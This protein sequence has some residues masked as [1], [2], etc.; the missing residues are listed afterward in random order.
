M[1]SCAQPSAIGTPMPDA[2]SRPELLPPSF[3][4]SSERAG[5]TLLR[6]IL[7]THRDILSPDE[8]GVG[9]L[10][11]ALVDV[12][13]GI[14]GEPPAGAR[15]RKIPIGIGS[16]RG[17]LTVGDETIGR[18]R[19]TLAQVLDEGVRAKGKRL[20][21]DKTPR[22]YTFAW[23]L[24]EI[25]PEARFLCLHRHC[26]DVVASCLAVMRFGAWPE[27]R[28]YFHES[29]MDHVRALI[30]AWV[31]KTET[32]LAFEE[33]FPASCLRVQYESL[34]K[35]PKAIVGGICGFLGVDD[36][37]TLID[38][39]F[40]TPHAQRIARG[41][42]KIRFSAAIS[43]DS[44]GRGASDVPWAR[45][46]ALPAALRERVDVSLAKV[47]YAPLSEP[48]TIEHAAPGER[49]NDADAMSAREFFAWAGGRLGTAVAA[50]GAVDVKLNLVVPG[51]DGGTW[52][53]DFRKMTFTE[54]REKDPAA[55]HTIIASVDTLR[56][57]V[58]AEV[59]PFDAVA[60]GH[61][62]VIGPDD[63]TA[64]ADAVRILVHTLSA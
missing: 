20:W 30:T 44:V 36:D 18:V 54:A 28:D 57:I 24:R 37:P 17:R 51:D 21:C 53:A 56:R 64:V 49:P 38:R 3:I 11:N 10:A 2:T 45:V 61:L 9:T 35:E 52:V 8:I 7:D 12:D 42:D 62:Q 32:I 40:V 63:Y 34:V 41:D 33:A 50:Q 31:E 55:S 39:T 48:S 58:R 59:N 47:G 22:N 46:V 15:A 43:R 23:L 16:S 5:S 27:F 13:Q 6:V 1:L 25:L 19:R 60:E 4:L 14:Y 29:P 26:L